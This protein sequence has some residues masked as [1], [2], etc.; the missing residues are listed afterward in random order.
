MMQLFNKC[1]RFVAKQD[2][3]LLEE[4]LEIQEL[5]AHEILGT[6]V[7]S[8]ISTGSERG[9]YMDYN[10]N[11]A[12]PQVTG[13][14]A[15]LQAI[16]IG[17]DVTS[18]RKG[19]LLFAD[20]PHHLYAVLKEEN[21]LPIPEKLTP[22]QAVFC[23]FPAVSMSSLIPMKIRPTEPVLVT[24]L[25]L[26]GLMC[27]QILQN[28][29]YPVWCI[30]PVQ[31]RRETAEKCGLLHVVANSKDIPQLI[32]SFGAALECSGDE[33]AT[34]DC[35]DSL[36]QG[37]ELFLVGVPWR[38]STEVDGHSL[39]LKIFYGFLHVHSGWE[40]NLPRKSVEFLPDSNRNSLEKALQWISEG[41]IITEGIY[42]KVS[43]E[44]CSSVYQEI[45]EDRL[46]D[47]DTC[48]IFDWRDM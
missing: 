27:G 25:G 2:A 30:D 3:R 15:I 8:L 34:Y 18:I 24:G 46:Q 32:G 11:M 48:V 44:D 28:F 5:Q 45:G 13:Y 42:R 17:K 1:V 40:W 10:D 6:T 36:R 4:M 41:R 9:G 31:K 29:G 7:V 39:L 38:K 19:A 33:L 37:G 12:Y 21:I 22:E 43:P 23:R 20:S 14:A 47:N 26:I 16:E 35:A